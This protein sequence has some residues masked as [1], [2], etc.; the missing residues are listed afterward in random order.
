MILTYI[1]AQLVKNDNAFMPLFGVANIIQPA[2]VCF[3]TNPDPWLQI[4]TFHTEDSDDDQQE[5]ADY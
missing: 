1:S 4:L 5:Q 3:Y 2:V